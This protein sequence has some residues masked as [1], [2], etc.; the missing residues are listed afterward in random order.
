LIVTAVGGFNTNS[1]LPYLD[2]ALLRAHPTFVCGYSDASALLLAINSRARIGVLH[3]PALLPQWGDPAGP[4]D[5]T[6]I[7]FCKSITIPTGTRSLRY[8]GFWCDP[9]TDWNETDRP[10]S[11]HRKQRFN[12]PWRVLRPGTAQGALV[13][14]NIETMNML[15]GTPYS[16]S[17]SRKILFIE[18]TGAEAYLPRFHRALTHLRIAGVLSKLSGL[19]VGR[20]PDAQPVAG[21]T[22]DDV[23]TD[24]L[25][26]TG[27]PVIVDVDLGHTE[28]IITLPIGAS[29]ILIAEPANVSIR[30]DRP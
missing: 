14:G 12:N 8:A 29:A 21:V 22:L 17:F 7:G 26:G 20:C 23:L 2:W 4:F 25:A 13:G 1:V 16:P 3:G 11:F 28:P 19:V 27:F 6:V 15:L 24:V 9:R 5:E 18:A 10:A 30:I